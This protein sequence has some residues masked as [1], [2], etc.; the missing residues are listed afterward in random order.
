M[1]Y[2]AIRDRWEGL[3]MFDLRF[4]FETGELREIHI[5]RSTGHS[6]LDGHTVSAL[7]LGG[8]NRI[9]SIFCGFQSTSPFLLRKLADTYAILEASK[10]RRTPDVWTAPAH[11][12]TAS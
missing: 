11:S 7:K 1:P 4:D 9:E 3:G 5:V 10:L 8:Q 2:Q 12:S 6:L